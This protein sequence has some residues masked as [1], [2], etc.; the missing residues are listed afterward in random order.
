M[1]KHGHAAKN[2]KSSEYA[3]WAAMRQRCNDPG[4][5]YY[6][7]YGG[8]GIRVCQKWN[9]FAAFLRDMGPRPKGYTLDRIDNDGNYTPGNCRWVTRKQNNRNRNNN[10]RITFAGRT[11]TITAWEEITGIKYN[12]IAWRLAR[13]WPVKKA[14]TKAALKRHDPRVMGKQMRCIRGHVLD[15][16]NLY[17]D[18]RGRSECLKCK[19]SYRRRRAALKRAEEG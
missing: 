6:H 12:T 11:E 1:T 9:S 7:C 19:R 5:R 2:T 10:R 3:T 16:N 18:P 4:H 17:T 13:G 14:L 15:L 8:R